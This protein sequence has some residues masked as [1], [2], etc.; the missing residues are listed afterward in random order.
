VIGQRSPAVRNR[1]E[2]HATW[3][4]IHASLDVIRLLQL[5]R[6]SL[7]SGAMSRHTMHAL[8]EAQDV[9]MLF[10]QTT[11]MTNGAYFDKFKALLLEVYQHLG[12]DVGV[13]HVPPEEMSRPQIRHDQL[14]QNSKWAEPRPKM[15]TSPFVFSDAA[16]PSDMVLSC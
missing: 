16:I 8:I 13:I 15:N 1:L 10:R 5:I 3:A 6:T 2:A 4:A 11:R 12:G 7:F 9:L 14:W